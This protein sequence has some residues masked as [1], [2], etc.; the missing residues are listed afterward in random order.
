M[1]G[2]Q[3]ER[4]SH[5]TQPFILLCINNFWLFSQTNK[6]MPFPPENGDVIQECKGWHKMKVGRIRITR[7]STNHTPC[8]HF[9]HVQQHFLTLFLGCVPRSNK[10]MTLLPQKMETLFMNIL[11]WKAWDERKAGRKRIT[12]N[13]AIHTPCHHFTP[14]HQQFLTLGCVP[15][16]NKQIPFPP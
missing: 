4:G 9:P 5:A 1:K 2:R 16:S 7:N 8:C 15:G 6:Q 14:L 13:S 10:Q 3:G 12:R 11:L